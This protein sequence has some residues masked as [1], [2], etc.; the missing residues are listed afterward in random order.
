MNDTGTEIAK[1]LLIIL[2]VVGFFYFVLPA[3]I[4]ALYGVLFWVLFLKKK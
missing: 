2:S 1:G 3:L 4:R